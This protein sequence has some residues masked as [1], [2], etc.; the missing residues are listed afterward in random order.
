MWTSTRGHRHTPRGRAVFAAGVLGLGLGLAPLGAADGAQ[1][2]VYVRRTGC[3]D[4][5]TGSSAR[6]FCTIVKAAKVATAGQIV[7]VY[8][9]TYTGEVFPWHSGVQG[10]PITFRPVT[11]NAVTITGAR[12]G[13]TISNQSWI[14]VTGFTIKNTTSNGIYISNARHLSI[15]HST[16]Q[17]SGRRVSGATAYGVYANAMSNST[18]WANRVTANSGSGVFIAGGSTANQVIGND[19]SYNANGFV[20]NAVGIDLRA[21]GNLISGNR[22]HNNEDSGIQL[23]PGG[24]RNRIVNNV[25]YANKGF[26]TVAM[27][28]CAHPP[29]GRTTG[30]ITGDHGIDSFGTTGGWIIGNTV[31]GNATAGINL[32]GLRAG[33]N[34]GYRIINN[35]AVDNAINCSNGAGGL[36]KC[37]RNAGNVR[38]DK[39]SVLGTVLDYDLVNLSTPGTMMVWGSTSYSSLAAMKAAS[40]QDK[41]GRQADPRFVNPGGAVYVLRAGSPAIDS[42]NSSAPG[43]SATDA[44]Y[45]RRVDDPATANTGVGV[46]SYDDRGAYEFQP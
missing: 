44:A 42:A 12:H 7:V 35:I 39:N 34:S 38:V 37:P 13:F 43:Q 23:F 27:T 5:G 33:T 45:R 10:R 31:Y 11:G 8:A 25:V 16:V 19:I 24:D 18:L 17:G 30:C 41:H 3:S 22:V 29:T 46:R 14:T 36:V 4:S 21:P 2:Y 6:P 40:G 26:T 32:E 9:G 28:N 15:S 20:R 1:I